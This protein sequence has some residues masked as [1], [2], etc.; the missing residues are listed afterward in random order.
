MTTATPAVSTR[1]AQQRSVERPA[2]LVLLI[3]VLGLLARVG[4][5]AVIGLGVDESYAVSVA[6]HASLSFFDHP[7]LSFW[8][9]GAAARLA[10]SEQRVIVRLPFILLFA[11]TAW[12]MFRLGARLFG[13]WAGVYAA[14][15]LNIAPV[16]SVSTGGWVL[17]DGPLMFFMLASTLCLARVLVDEPPTVH[18]TR[19]WAA[20]GLFMGLALLSKYHGAFLAAGTLLFVITTPG[21]RRWL[22]H[23]GPYIGVA[24]AAVLLTPVLLWNARHGWVSFR[25]QGAR[26]A[27]HG[28]HV[29]PLLQSLGG[30]AGYLLPWIW[31]PLV[32]ILVA[33]LARGP[34]D[35]A[36]WLLCCLAIGPIALFTL[37]TLGGSPGLPHWE[38]P[39]YLMLLPILGAA[40]AARLARDG[41]WTRR[42]LVGSTAAF[43]V[44]VIVLASDTATG[45]IARA[46]PALFRRGD[47]T[48]QALDWTELRR[49][50]ARRHLLD[51]PG[52][53]VA[54]PSWVQAGKVSHALGPGV[55]VL[56]FNTD[57][58]QF[59]Y[60]RDAR[61]FVGHDAL[62]V[63]LDDG[64]F[65]ARTTYAPYFARIEPLDPVVL[66]RA[67]HAVIDVQL[68]R[69]YALRRPYPAKV[70][71]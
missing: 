34:R 20:A 13:E 9:A 45:W 12:L 26:G 55:P 46:A 71:R 60:L 58:H 2:R 35:R 61:A 1:P 39:G 14:L 38:A 6:R 43:V 7:P 69:A 23:P 63:A 4:L 49:A 29:T 47:P 21:A 50:V 68:Y 36:R 33:A 40:T 44:L 8:M 66:H 54:V 30:Q 70:P 24:I 11:G 37:I 56:C 65:D 17:P 3:I 25:F 62:L 5:A 28:L 52:L 27:S 67:G 31:V 48:L 64:R 15:L 42:W 32:W 57:P 41:V 16:F 22:R 51:E 18:A 59:Y 19:W 53:F 10:G